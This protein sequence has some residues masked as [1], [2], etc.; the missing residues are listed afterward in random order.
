MFVG[1]PLPSRDNQGFENSVLPARMSLA[2]LLRPLLLALACLIGTAAAA[3]PLLMPAEL[4]TLLQ[5]DPGVRLIDVREGPAYAMQHLPGAVSAPYGR[6]RLV[7]ENL[8]LPP[9]P[10]EL[11][12]L[13]QELGL[14]PETR[15]VLV[16]TGIDATDFGGAARAYWTLKSLGVRQLSILNGGLA[17]WKAAGLPVTDEVATAPHSSWQ[18]RLDSQWL[19]TRDEVL[20]SL[21]QPEV[22]R[23]DA[24]PGPYFQ[25]RIAHENARA[26]G[27][28]PGAVHADSE[29]F[30]ELGSAELMDAASLEDEAQALLGDLDADAPIIAFCNAGHWSATDW[31]VLSE[32]L[33]RPHVRMY[34]GSMIDWTRAPDP[35]PMI[36]E[37]DR[38]DQLRYAALSWA[39]RNLG[40]RAP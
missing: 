10:Q 27:T 31:F 17:A 15:V 34:P 1:A 23:I 38:W 11:A 18:P 20:A 8:G 5:E 3:Q 4:Q 39:H 36:H 26:R 24:R 2:A 22:L 25:G 21:E 16:Y 13:A 33:G 19:A 7:D 12:E 30:F 35:L 32:V 29:A 14:T 28:L 9:T 40:T 37:P 6:W